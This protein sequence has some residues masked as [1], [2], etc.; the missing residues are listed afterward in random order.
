[1]KIRARV[2]MP[3]LRART[4]LYAL[5]LGLYRQEEQGWAPGVGR[6]PLESATNN[7]L[8]PSVNIMPDTCGLQREW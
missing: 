8:K 7:R 1:M 4:A 3:E 2:H 6:G 5:P